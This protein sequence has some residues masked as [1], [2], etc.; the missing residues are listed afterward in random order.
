MKK[1]EPWKADFRELVEVARYRDTFE[2]SEA[3]SLE[4]ALLRGSGAAWGWKENGNFA[5]CPLQTV[6]L[7]KAVPQGSGKGFH[8]FLAER[9]EPVEFWRHSVP[10]GSSATD[11]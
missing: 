11:L 3:F 10:A 6:S 8:I 5:F 4:I 9:S 2:T 7:T 1:A